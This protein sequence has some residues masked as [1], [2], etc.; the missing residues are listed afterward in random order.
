MNWKRRFKSYY[1]LKSTERKI[2]QLQTD[3]E[4]TTFRNYMD[5][6]MR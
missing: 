6:E 1:N 3:F 5:T 4:L 2:R